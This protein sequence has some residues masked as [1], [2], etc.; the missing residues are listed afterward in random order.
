MFVFERK[1][2]SGGARELGSGS[3]GDEGLGGANSSSATR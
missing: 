2:R 1:G 3:W